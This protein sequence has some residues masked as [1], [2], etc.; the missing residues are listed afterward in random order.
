MDVTDRASSG[1]REPTEEELKFTG[2]NRGE[3]PSK[4]FQKLQ[5]MTG[6]GKLSVV[7]VIMGA[8]QLVTTS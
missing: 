8:S 7:V 1:L 3:I 6:A 2:L 4:S 5:Y